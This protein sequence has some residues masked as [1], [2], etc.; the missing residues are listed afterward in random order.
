MNM[1]NKYVL[2]YEDNMVCAFLVLCFPINNFEGQPSIMQ[3][4]A[5]V[6][7][8][9]HVLHSYK[10]EHSFILQFKS[11][12]ILLTDC[13]PSRGCTIVNINVNNTTN[14]AS[15]NRVIFDKE[16]ISLLYKQ[17][18][19]IIQLDSCINVF[20]KNVDPSANMVLVFYY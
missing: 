7:N 19:L 9:I 2:Y 5:R 15:L 1:L 11:K 14:D 8:N 18:I 3:D 10:A 16:R 4:I 17:S 12:H 13:D 20:N 6:M